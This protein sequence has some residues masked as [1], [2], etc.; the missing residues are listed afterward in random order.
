[1]LE[2]QTAYIEMKKKGFKRPV[3]LHI[4]QGKIYRVYRQI[5]TTVME[6]V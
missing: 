2:N 6:K 1:M 4:Q 3:E 5:I